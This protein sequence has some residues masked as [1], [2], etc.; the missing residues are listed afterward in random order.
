MVGGTALHQ[1]RTSPKTLRLRTE[2]P[3][4]RRLPRT[5]AIVFRIRTYQVKVDELLKEGIGVATGLASAV[6]SWP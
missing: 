4:L 6:G 3:T 2:R 1:S 5:G